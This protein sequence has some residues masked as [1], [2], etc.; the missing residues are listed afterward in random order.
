MT[1]ALERSVRGKNIRIFDRL[2]AVRI[3]SD[4]KKAHGVLCIDLQNQENPKERYVCSSARI[5]S[6]RPA[7]RREFTGTAFIR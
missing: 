1:E 6:G 2:Q 4:G 5:S 7:G 3:L